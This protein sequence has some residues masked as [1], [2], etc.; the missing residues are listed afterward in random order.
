[1]RWRG[2]VVARR[3]LVLVFATMFRSLSSLFAPRFLS[4]PARPAESPARAWASTLAIVTA[5]VGLV[6]VGCSSESSSDQKPIGTSRANLSWDDSCTQMGTWSKFAE[7]DC[8]T[9]ISGAKLGCECAKAQ[10]WNGVCQPEAEARRAEADCTT[11]VI[12]CLTT[13]KECECRQKCIAGH[14]ACKAKDTP[15]ASCVTQTC[16]TYCK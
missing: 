12:Q 4:R 9:C 7:L 10:P 15:V 6:A 11:E 13:C 14:E 2:G 16:D 3:H 8:Q 1:M 5:C